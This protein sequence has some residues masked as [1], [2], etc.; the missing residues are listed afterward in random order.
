MWTASMAE[1]AGP[2][3]GGVRDGSTSGFA[4]SGCPSP[5]SWPRVTTTQPQGDRRWRGPGRRWSPSSTKCH[6]D[7]SLDLQGCGRAVSLSPG[8][9]G[10]TAVCGTPQEA[11][12]EAV[13]SSL[14]SFLTAQ[15]PEAKRKDEEEERTKKLEDLGQYVMLMAEAH[16]L[17]MLGK[18][19][20]TA[21]QRARFR[22]LTL[23]R[24]RR[25]GGR[26]RRG[27]RRS[28]LELHLLLTL[29]AI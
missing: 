27:G 2:P 4:T 28:F 15:A 21:E 13:E 22:V 17:L 12:G 1:H 26:G 24:P 19:A 25:G 6:G 16:G 23:L 18:P 3:R 11:S 20:W 29:L 9:G 8:R 10:V 5:W 7:R 14:L